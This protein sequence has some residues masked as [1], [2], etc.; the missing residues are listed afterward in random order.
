M[1]TQVED[2]FDAG[3]VLRVQ[4]SGFAIGDALIGKI[5]TVLQALAVYEGVKWFR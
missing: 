3:P 4:Q 1:S 5:R 2:L